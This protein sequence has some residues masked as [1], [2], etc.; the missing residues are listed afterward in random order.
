MV[1][2]KILVIEDSEVVLS[3]IQRA[4][5]AEGYEVVASTQIVGNARHLVSCD[6]VI[7][8]YHMPGLDG[9]SVVD[10]LKAVTNASASH[11][12][13]AFY[14][15]T[16][17]L[18]VAAR[19]RELGFDGVLHSKGDMVALVQQLRAILRSLAMR[20]MRHKA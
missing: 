12:R 8:D 13:P 11:Q 3:R 7:V 16:S 2:K 4:L 20:A 1:K 18:D 19:Y 17:D 14:L 5:V 15:Y 10:S 9:A 6:V